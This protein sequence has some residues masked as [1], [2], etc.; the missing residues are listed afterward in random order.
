MPDDVDMGFTAPGFGLC[1][2][3]STTIVGSGSNP[4]QTGR[5]LECGIG[6]TGHWVGSSSEIREEY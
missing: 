2:S 1:A 4:M 6:N 5:V 3:M